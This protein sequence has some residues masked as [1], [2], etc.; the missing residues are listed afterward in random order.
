MEKGFQITNNTVLAI[1]SKNSIFKSNKLATRSFSGDFCS[2]LISIKLNEVRRCASSA[3][4]ARFATTNS[5][6][7]AQVWRDPFP[8]KFSEKVTT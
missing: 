1:L 4:A 6:D 7:G 3:R 2:H 5:F 8:N